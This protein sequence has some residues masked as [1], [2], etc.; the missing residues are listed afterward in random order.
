MTGWSSA[1]GGAADTITA[2]T[3]RGTDASVTGP[4]PC[5]AG[6]DWSNTS[7]LCLSGSLPA[8][9]ASN[10]DYTNN[11]GI[12]LSIGATINTD[13]TLGN[14]GQTLGQSFTS[15][16]IA[17]TG[18][19]LSGLRAQV[20]RRGDPSGTFYCAMMTPGTAI[21]FTSFATKCYDTPPDGVALTLA[22]V[23]NIDSIAV[24]VSSGP[25]AITVTNLC[26]TGITFS[27]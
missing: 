22:D 23:P 7:A 6:P 9:S 19:P 21:P 14:F 12:M 10:P 8:L 2:P 24:Q 11:W 13:G 18:S 17:V 27:M 26:I 1:Y 4:A 3:C 16:A 20:T 5:A 25:T 15:I